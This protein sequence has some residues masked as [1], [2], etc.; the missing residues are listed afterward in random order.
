MTLGISGLIAAYIL[1]AALLL[2]VNLYSKWSWQLKTITIII[3]SVF[4][5]I[6]YI[7]FP[8]LLGWPTNQKL[9]AHFRLLATEVHQPDKLTGEEGS[10][11]LW[12]KEVED[13]T[14]LVLPRAYVL[15]Y[16]SLLHEK[17]INVQSKID[18]G[19]PQLGEYEEDS[20]R[21][22]VINSSETGQ[23]SLDIQFY[24]LPDPLFP[25]K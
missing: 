14:T 16:S 12:L 5:I 23:K 3:T 10:V 15:P 24:D 1:L 8:P 19:I 20:M 2:S 7:S 18:R 9:P 4:Y 22:E 25:E 21:Q 17:I 13:I 11:F 6:S